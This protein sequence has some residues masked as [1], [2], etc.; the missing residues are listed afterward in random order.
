M[1]FR[2]TVLLMGSPTSL[3]A[4]QVYWPWSPASTRQSTSVPL[5]RI[6]VSWVRPPRVVTV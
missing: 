6:S 5:P 4:L 2:L 3:A 1:I